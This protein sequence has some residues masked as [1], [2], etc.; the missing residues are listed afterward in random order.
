[1]ELAE[2]LSEWTDYD[3]AMFEF[4][5]SLGIFPEGTTFGGIRGMFFMETPLST[6][7][8]EAMDAL[9]KIGVLAYREAEY[10]W[11]GPV[12]FSAVR[13]ATSGDE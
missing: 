7:I 9:V 2:S 6:A 4:G 1:M 5:R 10:R 3:I 13:R 11:V 8:G 12:D